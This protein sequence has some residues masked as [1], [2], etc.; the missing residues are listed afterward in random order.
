MKEKKSVR[1]NFEPD[2]P[3]RLGAE[4]KVYEASSLFELDSK[5]MESIGGDQIKKNVKVLAEEIKK[6]GSNELEAHREI[7]NE[8]V[9]NRVNKQDEFEKF[10]ENAISEIASLLTELNEVDLKRNAVVELIL[11]E[12]QKIRENLLEIDAVQGHIADLDYQILALK[13]QTIRYRD[14]ENLLAA[15]KAFYEE[16]LKNKENL[17][18]KLQG[19]KDSAGVVR[20]N[21]DSVI[22]KLEQ[23]SVFYSLKLKNISENEENLSNTNKDL[24]KTLSDL[25]VKVSENPKENLPNGE[26]STNERYEKLNQI[27][28]LH[29]KSLETDQEYKE[30]FTTSLL[31]KQSSQENL[32]FL[33]RSL[34]ENYQNNI[35]NHL[36][37]YLNS[38][39]LIFTEQICCIQGDISSL[40]ES[41]SKFLKFDSTAN[42]SALKTLDGTSLYMVKEAETI[43]DQC[44]KINEIMENVTEKDKETNRVK[45]VMTEIKLR[46]P[47]FIPKL[48]DP[49][50]IA[51]FEYIKALDQ[52]IPIPF[53]REEPGVYL[54][55]TKRIFIKLENGNIVIRIGGGFTSI[56]NFIEIYTPI[57]LERQ[58]EAVEEALPVFKSTQARLANSPQ[59]GMS[60]HR[61]VK[62][63]HGTVEAQAN[64]TPIKAFRKTPIKK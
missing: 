41:L 38:N 10:T 6:L 47:P 57:E 28:Q 42:K 11:K 63:L 59:K 26:N 51:L 12:E 56:S 30:K 20:N 52:P 45:A 62:I 17:K 1:I 31:S 40:K 29:S 44:T 7:L 46:H 58:E 35:K 33:L 24:K 60:P 19:S 55:G 16:S 37:I 48:D 34:E 18:S 15:S 21:S 53:T 2:A 9:L 14:L 5:R 25:K 4:V 61:A 54:F 64:G 22:S 39:E 50:D 49:I 13:A 8:K 27:S 43:K 32:L 3:L 23:E 36:D